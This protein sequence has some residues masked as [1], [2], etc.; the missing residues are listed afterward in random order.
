MYD[1]I[2]HKV[3]GH[4]YHVKDGQV[5]AVVADEGAVEYNDECEEWELREDGM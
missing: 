2:H 4:T 3:T 5:D 1:T